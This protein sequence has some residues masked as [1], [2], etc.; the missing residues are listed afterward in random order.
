MRWT[1]TWMTVAAGL[2]CLASRAYAEPDAQAAAGAGVEAAPRPADAPNG[3]APLTAAQEAELLTFLKRMGAEQ[4]DRLVQ[5]KSVNPA[6]YVP[7]SRY[8]YEWMQGI[9]RGP[10]AL[11]QPYVD[12]Q[13]AYTKISQMVND[14]RTAVDAAQK[15]AI[16]DQLRVA[17][18]KLFDT[19]MKI[20][21]FKLKQ[22]Q[23]QL[24]QLESEHQSNLNNRPRLI[25]DSLQK[26]LATATMPAPGQT[27]V[28]APAGQPTTAPAA[29][30]KPAGE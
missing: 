12:L 16:T 10:E 22:L 30:T 3:P 28:P 26:W 27:A 17:V 4:Y 21:Q 18:A 5:L 8:W 13:E 2:V 29:T 15:K 6:W 25:E 1:A 24:R 23:D 20:R 7:T 14:Y 9:K 11:W 19:Q